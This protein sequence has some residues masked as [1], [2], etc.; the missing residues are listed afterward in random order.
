MAQGLDRLC[1]ACIITSLQLRNTMRNTYTVS[2]YTLEGQQGSMTLQ[3][4][5]EE[6]ACRVVKAKHY[7]CRIF[8]VLNYN[9]Y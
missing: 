8:H 5:S 9:L 4:A 1:E 7:G 2:Y 3:A 6:E